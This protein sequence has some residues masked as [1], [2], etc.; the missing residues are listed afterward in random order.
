MVR[1]S[2]FF[3]RPRIFRPEIQI[4]RLTGN[5]RLLVFARVRNRPKAEWL[6]GTQ[7]ASDEP[8][9][10]EADQAQSKSGFALFRKSPN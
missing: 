3:E 1:E 9:L 6:R 2:A 7:I 8:T 5:G 10:S 4:D